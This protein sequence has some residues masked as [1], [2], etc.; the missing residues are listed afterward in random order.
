MA[1]G[2]SWAYLEEYGAEAVQAWE[3]K[4][5]RAK[6]GNKPLDRV[7]WSNHQTGLRKPLKHTVR[8][9]TTFFSYLPGQT[10]SGGAGESLSH[11]LLK[12]AIAGMTGTKL[13][14]SDGFG[15]HQIQVTHGETE[16]LILDGPYRADAYLRFTSESRLGLRWSGEVY[17]EV[18]HKHAVPIEKEQALQAAGAPVI[19]VTLNDIFLY[20][21]GHDTTTAVKEAAHI[22]R[23][24]NMLQKGFLKG[25]VI[26][27]RISV[28][29]L[30][31]Q[32]GWLQDDVKRLTGE[33]D[34]AHK[35]SARTTAQLATATKRV[36]EL[37]AAKKRLGTDLDDMRS[38]RDA[39]LND[40]DIERGKADGLATDLEGTRAALAESEK[41]NRGLWWLTGAAILA[42]AV[43]TGVQIA[44]RFSSSAET[45][46]VEVATPAPLPTPTPAAAASKPAKKVKRAQPAKV[47]ATVSEPLPVSDG[48]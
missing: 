39:A 25:V 31:E 36:A 5:E 17:V 14:L 7:F 11:K 19:E 13:I 15:E 38:Q 26:G 6:Y 28:E 42:L 8:G 20:G 43:I 18:R 44:R 33:L 21:E 32:V 4:Q 41:E 46:P 22:A 48:Q 47:P 2:K 45:A 16:K 37:E 3:L 30:R 12:R 27:D 40:C 35:T 9:E 10:G 29:F 34:A 24:R 23:M 1:V